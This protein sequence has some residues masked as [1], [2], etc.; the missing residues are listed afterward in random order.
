MKG[1]L[2]LPAAAL[3][4]VANAAGDDAAGLGRLAEVRQGALVSAPVAVEG[5]AG[6]A[7]AF[8]SPSQEI[9]VDPSGGGRIVR[10]QV[11]GVPL[12]YSAGPWGLMVPAFWHPRAVVLNRPF[13]TTLERA[14]LPG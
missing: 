7:V 6:P 4:A 3:L 13:E 2:A 9:V 12:A 1:L 14:I 11:G 8:R 10:W 5:L